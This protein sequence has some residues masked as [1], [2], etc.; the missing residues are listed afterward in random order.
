MKRVALGILWVFAVTVNAQAQ[1][2]SRN[3]GPMPTMTDGQLHISS[4]GQHV[5]LVQS[6]GS[7]VV[8]VVDGV[9]GEPWD[10]IP[11]LRPGSSTRVLFSERGGHYAYRARRGGE[12]FIVVDG[13]PRATSAE[14]SSVVFSPDGQRF[15]YA[16]VQANRTSSTFVVDGASKEIPGI[17]WSKDPKQAS[18]IFSPDG[19]RYA[20]TTITGTAMSV[21]L[22]GQRGASFDGIMFPQFSADSRRFLYLG[23]GGATAKDAVNGGTLVVDGKPEALPAEWAASSH[24]TFSPDGHRYAFISAR[25]VGNGSIDY[26]LVIDGTPSSSYFKVSEF[27]FSPD[28]KHIGAVAL[29]GASARAI[30]TLDGR[31][32]GPEYANAS[33]VQFTGD[34]AHI[35]AIA[36]SPSGAF[37]AIDG[38]EAGPYI[39]SSVL[40]IAVSDV[41][42]HYA[43]QAR[44]SGESGVYQIIVDGQK[45]AAAQ[46][47]AIFAFSQNGLRSAFSVEAR[48]GR[49][50]YVDKKALPYVLGRPAPAAASPFVFSPDAVHLAFVGHREASGNGLVFDGKIG[51]EGF[52]LDFLKFSSD[53]KHFAFAGKSDAGRWTIF[54]DGKSV[55]EVD[56]LFL[57]KAE[58]WGFETDDS[59]T[60]L[61]VVA[62]QITRMTFPVQGG[63]GD[64]AA[65]LSRIAPGAGA[66]SSVVSAAN[67]PQSTVQNAKDKLSGFLRGRRAINSPKP[68]VVPTSTGCGM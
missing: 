60:V 16:Y 9:E 13:K 66:K 27:C 31:Q 6:K 7:R 29:I 41:G 38:A 22:D 12:N 33:N 3:F 49:C 44:T 35:I 59:L 21:T 36:S 23:T 32:V 34:S 4:A 62:G 47:R 54:L 52:S 39:T 51:A 63:A 8:V 2:A 53:S 18:I 45:V 56:G 61:A 1:S 40:D 20:Y 55:S 30:I 46:E 57:G 5:G 50:V 43:Y 48:S 24:P 19:K 37:F 17:L 15:A 14:F 68:L 67:N 58:T 28:S 26:R 25:R 65:S 64:V 11:V 42:G 10:E